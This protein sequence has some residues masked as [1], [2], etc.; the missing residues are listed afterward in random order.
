[1]SAGVHAE[2]N[3][4]TVIGMVHYFARGLDFAVHAMRERRWDREPFDD[5]ATPVR[6]LAG[7]PVGILGYGGIG[8]AIAR[9]ALAL[10]MRVIAL[11]RRPLPADPGIE[12]LTGPDGLARLLR[13]SHFVVLA[14]PRTQATEYLLDREHLATLRP[15]AVLI[16]VGRGELVDENALA[17]LLADG[18]IRG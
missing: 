18:A 13:E 8:R 10:D 14:L 16:N 9:R 15:D 3:A 12:L 2:P 4:D 6:E 7:A 17:R 1:N 11:R 5:P